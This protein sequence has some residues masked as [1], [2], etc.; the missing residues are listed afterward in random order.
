MPAR[1]RGVLQ[2]RGGEADA[3]RADSVQLRDPSATSPPPPT[4]IG[5]IF[6]G[7]SGE[8]GSAV[9]DGGGGGKGGRSSERRK[10]FRK[11]H[12]G[13]TALLCYVGCIGSRVSSAGNGEGDGGK[14]GVRAEDHQCGGDGVL[15]EGGDC[16]S[17]VRREDGGCR[18]SR[19]GTRLLQFVA[20][21]TDAWSL[22]RRIPHR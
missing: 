2:A 17:R 19:T 6:L 15:P 12:G 16:G 7:W 14:R 11:V 10:V 20:G 18:V 13:G 4:K 9:G 1:P 3:R 22:Q 8:D 21:K 5:R